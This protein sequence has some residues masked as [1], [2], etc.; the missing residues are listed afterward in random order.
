VP[1]ILL[2]SQFTLK[3]PDRTLRLGLASVL[4]LSGLK[5]I[6]FAG[7]DYVIAVGRGD[8]RAR[9]RDLGVHRASRAAAGHGRNRR[10][11]PTKVAGPVARILPTVVVLALLGCTAAAFAVT[12]GL[13]LEH[14]PISP[15]KREQ[16]DC[17][18]LRVE[19][20]RLDSV[21]A[22]QARPCDRS[23]S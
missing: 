3:V 9:L 5:L 18:R 7:A 4:M 20:D 6:D 11:L 17:A 10:P 8:R 21:P 1:G 23:R 14:S 19:L 15:H 2:T 13:K 16:G 22:A 12:E